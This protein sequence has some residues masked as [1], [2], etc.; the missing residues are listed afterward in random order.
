MKLRIIIALSLITL[1]T[2]LIATFGNVMEGVSYIDS[3]GVHVKI[4]GFSGSNV[5]GVYR[6]NKGEKAKLIVELKSG[7]LK[8]DILLNFKPIYSKIFN[9]SGICDVTFN[10]NGL[11]SLRLEGNANGKVDLIFEK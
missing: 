7:K 11:C 4:N 2:L 1:F 3:S 8:V 10:Q 5:F 6:V 9:K